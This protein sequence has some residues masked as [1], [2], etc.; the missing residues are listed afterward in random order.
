MVDVV[1]SSSWVGWWYLFVVQAKVGI[2]EGVFVFVIMVLVLVGG[3]VVVVLVV[4]KFL[5]FILFFGLSILGGLEGGGDLH[6]SYVIGDVRGIVDA[7]VHV[8]VCV[9]CVVFDIVF[10]EEVGSGVSCNVSV[11]S[12]FFDPL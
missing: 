9:Y 1:I 7:S 4:E 10:G 12:S 2:S 6:R 8:L 3:V 11:V 5:W